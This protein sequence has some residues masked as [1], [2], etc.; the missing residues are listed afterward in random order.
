MA[1]GDAVR[2]RHAVR[3]LADGHVG[4]VEQPAGDQV[5]GVAGEQ[6]L[7]LGDAAARALL[8]LVDAGAADRQ[9]AALAAVAGDA[10][11]ALAPAQQGD[12]A[13]ELR[14]VDVGRLDGGAELRQQRGGRGEVAHGVVVVAEAQLLVAERAQ[15]APAQCGRRRRRA[16]A[17]S[18]RAEGARL[19]VAGVDVASPPSRARRRPAP[20]ACADRRRAPRQGLRPRRGQP[21]INPSATTVIAARLRTAVSICLCLPQGAYKPHRPPYH[22]RP[23]PC[24][25]CSGTPVG[26]S[27]RQRQPHKPPIIATQAARR[28]RHQNTARIPMP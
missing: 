4:D 3:V 15:V 5:V 17:A 8:V 18:R 19:R 20:R 21:R 2:R 13:F 10:V 14:V 12:G 26:L 9:D 22:R 24:L 7:E 1:G 27:Y 11:A 6:R 25:G 16:G 28:S 23:V